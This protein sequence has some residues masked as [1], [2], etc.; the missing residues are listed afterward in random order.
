[1][2]FVMTNVTFLRNF[3]IETNKIRKNRIH[4]SVLRA[5]HTVR[6]FLS[7]TAFL[8]I[9]WNGWHACQCY[10]SHYKTAI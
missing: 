5:I 4:R 7:V 2:K 9:A 10:C 8:Y 1:M 3:E 6:F